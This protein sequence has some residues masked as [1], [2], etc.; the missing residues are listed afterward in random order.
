[1]DFEFTGERVVPGQVD[2][3]LWNEHLA[4]YAFAAR[5]SRARRVL[6]LGCGTGYGSDELA[7]LAHSVIAVD[8]APGALL[9]ARS[10][11]E[12]RNLDFSAADGAQLP[13]RDGSFD[14][15]VA[16][17]VIE[18]LKDWQGL[19][20]EARR[21][22]APGGQLIVSTPNKLYY[23]ESRQASGPN[24]YHE[25]EFEYEE[26]RQA[27]AQ[28]F[29]YVSLFLQN[30]SEGLLFQSVNARGAA[31]VRFESAGADPTEC[32]FFV[33]VC[34]MTPQTGSPVFLYIPQ[35]GNILREREHHIQKLEGELRTKDEWLASQQQEHL[36]L[37][38][39]FRAQ[40]KEL[41]KSNQW[42]AE[43]D[44]KLRAAGEA[45]A[46]L[47]TE[48]QQLHRAYQSQV[49]ALEHENVQ[50]TEWANNLGAELETKRAE[51]VQAVEYLHAAETTVQERTEW[52][53]RLDREKLALEAQLTLVQAS[54]WV[55]LG[56][57]IGLGPEIGNA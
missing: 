23:A 29:P 49:A 46:A 52:A 45:I 11:Y 38:E 31:D 39:Q 25:H 16:F 9:Q 44:D 34:A 2:R 22:L 1:M 7:S 30:H 53:Q 43:L 47:Q 6:D 56:R 21:V 50:K 20:F 13:F 5:L 51:L 54:R 41:E 33:G 36:G 18:H 4:R 37:L 14:L 26:F 35:S 57:K 8:I 10:R 12:R 42:A 27:L 28:H 17:E 48:I 55:K 15:V 32:S 24:P 3:N 19:L 40:T